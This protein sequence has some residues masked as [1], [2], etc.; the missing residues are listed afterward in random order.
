[1]TTVYIS[2]GT[3]KTG[4]TALQS[5]MRENDKLMEKQGY[6][7][8]KL[9]L[10][11]PSLYR[12][13]NAQFLVYRSKDKGEAH[14][15][16]VRR[17][18][19]EQL[20]RYAEKFDNIVISDELI[21]YR[22]NEIENFWEN[23]I[24]EF[25]KIHCKIKVIVY[26]RRQDQVIQSLWNQNVK[27]FMRRTKSFKECIDGNAFN[28]FPLDYYKQLKEI[29]KHI[30]RENLI[31]RPYER[32]QFEGEENSIFSDFFKAVGLKLTNE[33]TK[34]CVAKNVG[35]NGNYIEIKR[36][37]NGIPQYRELDD[38]MSR[39]ILN[40]SIYADEIYGTVKTSMFTHEEQIEYMQQFE[41]SNK[42]VAKEYLGREDSV[43][44]YES[45]KEQPVWK[46]NSDTMYK[47]LLISVTEIFCKQEEKIVKLEQQVAEQQRQMMEHA[48]VLE[49]MHNSL[50]FRVYR[51]IRKIFKGNC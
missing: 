10:D 7:Y 27:M 19:F 51:K 40:A 14:Q 16:E 30:G 35:L 5:F 37:I 44:Y 1:M 47:D 46:V 3:P 38:F 24:D 41:E 32:G 48:H 25:E 8:P 50:I 22:C 49:A 45:I 15:K 13:R 17:K 11:I 2:I 28:Y 36:I 9:D 34:D 43:M 21:W 31:V 29:E 12:N 23:T 39:P 4:T 18:A 42:K 6:C 20:G 26:L 33:F